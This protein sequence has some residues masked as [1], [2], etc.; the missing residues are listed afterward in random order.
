LRS[1]PAPIASAADLLGEALALLDR[2]HVGARPLRGVGIQLAELVAAG[3]GAR[4]LRLF[5]G[6]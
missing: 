3:E 5:P 2:A 4:Q 1:L 6:G